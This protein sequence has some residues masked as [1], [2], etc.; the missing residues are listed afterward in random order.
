MRG[1]VREARVCVCVA[2]V[3]R[4]GADDVVSLRKLQ[5]DWSTHPTQWCRRP[6]ATKSRCEHG[7]V[8]TRDGGGE[9]EQRAHAEREMGLRKVQ[10]RQV[11][12][13]TRW[14]HPAV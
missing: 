5:D 6:R 3:G 9:P 8:A 4:S 1:R 2:Q 10:E 11:N 13:R 14:D 7:A 12:Q